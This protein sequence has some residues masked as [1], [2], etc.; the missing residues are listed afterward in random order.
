MGPWAV[1][2]S[3]LRCALHAHTTESDGELSPALLAAHY[4]RAGFDVLAITD[5]WAV[6]ELELGASGILVIP[7]VELNCVLPGARDGHVLGLGVAA[8]AAEL[9]ELA[10]GYAGLAETG[11]WIGARGGIAY[12]AHPYWTGVTPG[13]LELPES[14][15]GIEIY[16]AGCDLEVGR[17]LS[18]VH[19]DELLE[20]GRLCPAIA[21]DDSHHPGFDS[22]HAWT[23]A[24]VESRSRE[25]VLEA[26]R[27][28]TF[29]ASTGPTIHDLRS[30][31]EAVVVRCS[32]ARSVTLVAAKT[33]GASVTAGRLGYRHNADVVKEDDDGLVTAAQLR[34]PPGTRH[35]RVEVTDPAGKRAWSGPFRA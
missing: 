28:G 4:A 31:G 5:H 34:V 16:N 29:Y 32:P 8:T 26:L 24:R 33:M 23:W 20:A 30:D 35:A 27:D 2:G 21:T 22:G 3:W 14:V 12:L 11:A 18:S 7:G 19:W 10:A 9:R 17:G 1:N 15:T 6:A 25:A 13:T